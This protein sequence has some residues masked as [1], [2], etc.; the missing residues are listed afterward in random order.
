M[1]VVGVFVR[2]FVHHHCHT[3]W[4]RNNSSICVI[5]MDEVFVAKIV[6]R[7]SNI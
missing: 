4:M 7:T 2:F 5:E 1:E 6:V 3:L